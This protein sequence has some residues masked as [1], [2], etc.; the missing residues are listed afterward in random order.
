MLKIN[1]DQFCLHVGIR[2][3]N[4]NQIE[5]KLNKYFL[6]LRRP[7]LVWMKLKVT[8]VFQ[9]YHNIFHNHDSFSGYFSTSECVE[10]YKAH[11]R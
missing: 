3:K 4:C 2:L 9:S 11:C 8:L 10:D 5:S 1:F 6:A 7:A